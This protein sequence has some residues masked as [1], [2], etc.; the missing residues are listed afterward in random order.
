MNVENQTI[1]EGDNLN[2]LRRLD[3]GTIDLIYVDSPFNSNKTY[4]SPIG[5][6]ANNTRRRM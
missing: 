4:E 1:F 3:S 2:I 6:E 5:N